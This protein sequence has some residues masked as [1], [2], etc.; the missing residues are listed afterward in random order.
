MQPGSATTPCFFAE[1]RCIPLVQRREVALLTHGLFRMR[2]DGPKPKTTVSEAEQSLAHPDD[3]YVSPA[4]GQDEARVLML[5]RTLRK[6][7]LQPS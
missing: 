7:R 1:S 3:D 5:L 2:T 4:V 6:Y